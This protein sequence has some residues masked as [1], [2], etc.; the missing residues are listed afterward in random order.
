MSSTRLRV[1]K[2][3]NNLREAGL[4]PIQMW[5]P[6]TRNPDLAL[7]CR[8]QSV[9][10]RQT[11]ARDEQLQQLQHAALVDLQDWTE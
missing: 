2:H 5:V 8:H 6:D 10:A 3:R 9:L 4:R 7:R 1:Q 11:D